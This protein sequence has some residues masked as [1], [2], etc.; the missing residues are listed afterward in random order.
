MRRR[1]NEPGTSLH[2]DPPLAIFPFST[3]DSEIEKLDTFVFFLFG[4]LTSQDLGAT[5]NASISQS[6][7]CCE[8]L[9]HSQTLISP[10]IFSYIVD[11]SSVIMYLCIYTTCYDTR[12]VLLIDSHIG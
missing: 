1:R 10:I 6:S 12:L 4:R 7:R 2:T 3:T 5:L 11:Q 9:S 8:L